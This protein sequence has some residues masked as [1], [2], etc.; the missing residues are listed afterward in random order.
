MNN[1]IVGKIEV[2]EEIV[3]T[4]FLVTRN[5]VMTAKH[6]FFNAIY[7]GFDEDQDIVFYY[8]DEKI[9]GKTL[10][11]EKSI[12]NRIDCVLIKLDL[13]LLEN[14]NLPLVIP[15]NPVDDFACK[16]YGYP[17]GTD[18]LVVFEG[19]ISIHD[20]VLKVL[21]KNRCHLQN[22]KGVSGAPI[23]VGENIIGFITNQESENMISGFSLDYVGEKI[24]ISMINVKRRSLY[25]IQLDYDDFRK[26]LIIKTNI[27]IN[28]LK[29]RYSDNLNVKTNTYGQLINLLENGNFSKICNKLVNETQ[30]IIKRISYVIGELDD[31]N[32]SFVSVESMHKNLLKLKKNLI[33]YNYDNICRILERLD[34]DSYSI[35][36][37][38]IY[39]SE[40]EKL[41]HVSDKKKDK[42]LN[43]LRKIYRLYTELNEHFNSVNINK[44]YCNLIIVKGIGGSG[45]THLLCDIVQTLLENGR[46]ALLMTG[47]MFS[48]FYD[49]DDT[50]KRQYSNACNENILEYLDEFGKQNGVFIPIC[51]DAINETEDVRYW[52]SKLPLYLSM[53]KQYE[54]L[55]LIISC[56]SIYEKEWLFVHNCG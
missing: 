28:S 15:T 10:N 23:V 34:N 11:L 4:G 54:N 37:E 18:N 22:Y 45:K 2:N 12:N 6:L 38:I 43:E 42:I 33:D 55:K 31:C 32:V 53:L 17:A 13:N 39:G 14:D 29:P 3:G 50:I 51:I 21:L 35:L 47:D 49:I 9:H 1:I 40:K 48:D 52:N 41:N 36:D 26:N 44:F 27:I 30:D 16:V 25:N 56:R 8:N 20:G 19:T 46:P 5:I 24:D 7:D